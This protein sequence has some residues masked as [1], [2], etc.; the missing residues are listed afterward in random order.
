M[1]SIH[2][3]GSGRRLVHGLVARVIGL[4]AV[5]PAKINVQAALEA[6]RTGQLRPVNGGV[7]SRAGNDTGGTASASAI[8][9]G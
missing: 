9:G 5:L 6:F 7:A 3:L 1:P 2:V 8:S 4:E